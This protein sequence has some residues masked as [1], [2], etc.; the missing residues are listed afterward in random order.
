MKQYLSLFGLLWLLSACT[1][2]SHVEFDPKQGDRVDY[3]VQTKA[4]IDIGGRVFT[5]YSNSLMHY[6]VIETSPTL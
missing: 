2:N 4:N 5:Q 3:W 1:P 6:E